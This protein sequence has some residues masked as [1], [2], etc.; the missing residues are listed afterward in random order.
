MSTPATLW[1]MTT[2]FTADQHFG[3]TNIIDYCGRPFASVGEMNEVLV[4]RWNARV[5]PD[6][7]VWVL[8]DVAMGR[9]DESLEY[10]AR[11]AGRKI[12][13]AG[14]HDRCWYGHGDRAVDWMERYLDAGFDEIAQGS[15]SIELEGTSIVLSHFPYVGDSGDTERY[16][17]HRPPDDGRWLVH[18]HV[19]DKWS[20]RGRMINVGV[21]VRDFTPVSEHEIAAIISEAL[22]GV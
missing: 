9:I 22:V 11:L 8:G 13:V 18:G 5:A 17:E 20:V 1:C 2:W 19:H 14:N 12:L 7:T 15:P 21:D 4:E 16:V 6:D 3:H 10:V